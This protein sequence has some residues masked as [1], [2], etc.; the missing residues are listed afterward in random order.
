MRHSYV[1]GLRAGLQRWSVVVLLVLAS[2]THTIRHVPGN[3]KTQASDG[4]IDLV[5]SPDIS[6]KIIDKKIGINIDRWRFEI[7]SAVSDL[8]PKALQTE[9][10]R[11]GLL[12][13]GVANSAPR[14]GTPES[15]RLII[16]SID[17]DLDTGTT[18]FGSH[19]VTVKLG[20][21]Y[22]DSAG[23]SVFK[24]EIVGTGSESGIDRLTTWG[25]FGEL[26]K[27]TQGMNEALDVAVTNA[28]VAAAQ[29]TVECVELKGACPSGAVS[30]G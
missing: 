12:S 16:H 1:T 15:A 20:V 29:H 28:V 25:G 9:Y 11:V 27:F 3:F 5:M 14:R 10:A 13:V 21:Q 4:E 22:L 2:C 26:S 30:Q 19:E 18:V 23:K 6:Q 17:M 8:L 7:G 24:K